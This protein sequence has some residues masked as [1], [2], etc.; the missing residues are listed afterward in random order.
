MLANFCKLHSFILSSY[1]PTLTGLASKILPRCV[2]ADLESGRIT[3][4]YS[5]YNVQLSGGLSVKLLVTQHY[6]TIDFVLLLCFRIQRSVP[7]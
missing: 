6:L 3:V 4:A 2:T 7:S 1:P 5:A